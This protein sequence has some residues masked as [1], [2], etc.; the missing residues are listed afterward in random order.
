[1][2]AGQLLFNNYSSVS[3]HSRGSAALVFI[4][5]FNSQ[6]QSTDVFQSINKDLNVQQYAQCLGSSVILGKALPESR[7]WFA[8]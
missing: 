5:R 4:K 6:S 7:I 1:M 8:S 2:F 3:I